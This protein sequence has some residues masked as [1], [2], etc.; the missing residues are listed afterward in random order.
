MLR[1]IRNLTTTSLFGL[2]AVATI[3]SEAPAQ[4][5]VA[6][7]GMQVFDSRWNT[8]AFVEIVAGGQHTLARRS[9]GSVVAWGLN[10]AGQ[11]FV[12]VLPSGLSYVGLTAAGAH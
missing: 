9:D 7:R 1:R 3:A 11:C 6:G 5:L 2:S 4:S 10:H 12:P 8:E